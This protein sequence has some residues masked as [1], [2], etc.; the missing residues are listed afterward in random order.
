M[1]ASYRQNVAEKTREA[2]GALDTLRDALRGAGITL[3]SLRLDA[4]TWSGE[5]SHA[6]IELGRCNLGTARQLALALHTAPG[7]APS[8]TEEA[9]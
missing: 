2:E 7:A 6:L 3:P 9:S 8:E 4:T 5:A 1:T